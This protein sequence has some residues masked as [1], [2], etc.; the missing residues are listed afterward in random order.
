MQK[1]NNESQGGLFDD[2][3][4]AGQLL[5]ALGYVILGEEQEQKIGISMMI[6]C[7]QADFMC[8]K[9]MLRVLDSN[10]GMSKRFPEV[11]EMCLKQTLARH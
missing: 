9:R 8:A 2:N 11:R 10:A 7:I 3:R 5:K 4:I 1:R 6:D